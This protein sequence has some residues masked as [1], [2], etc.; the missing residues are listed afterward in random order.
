MAAYRIVR[1]EKGV[2]VLEHLNSVSIASRS[3]Y[4]TCSD[5]AVY[6]AGGATG[7]VILLDQADGSLVEKVQE[8]SFVERTG[9][10]DDGVRTA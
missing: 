10:R 7:D 8:L 1:N 5:T 2:P 4:V 6:S 9:Q 3:G